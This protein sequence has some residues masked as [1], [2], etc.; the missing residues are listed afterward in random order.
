MRSYSGDWGCKSAFWRHGENRNWH[1]EVESLFFLPI[2]FTIHK[3]MIQWDLE[4]RKQQWNNQPITGLAINVVIGSFF[5][6]CFVLPTILIVRESYSASNFVGLIFS[7][8]RNTL[9]FLLRLQLRRQQKSAADPALKILVA[10]DSLSPLV[11]YTILH[12]TLPCC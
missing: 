8:H 5:R 6:F 10:L 9:R 2:P 1:L 4:Y 12:I 7:M 3:S 11:K